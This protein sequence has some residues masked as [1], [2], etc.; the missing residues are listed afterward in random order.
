LDSWIF[1]GD[2]TPVRDVM[3]GGRWIVQD[4]RHALEDEL[5]HECRAVMERLAGEGPQLFSDLDS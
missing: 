3:V 5:K 2:D 1:S 4:R